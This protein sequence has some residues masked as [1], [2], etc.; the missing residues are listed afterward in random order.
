MADDLLYQLTYEK[1]A[2]VILISEQYQNRNSPRWYSDLLGTAA[3]WVPDATKV[4]VENH[5]CGSGFVWV[6][7]GEVLL[8]SCYLTPNESIGEFTEK[9]TSLEDTVQSLE[10]AAI[11]AGDFNAKAL[12]WGMPEP[13]RRGFSYW[14]WQPG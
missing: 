3:I 4:R 2:D 9:L 5:G 1:K 6:R 8:V 11:V 12:E 10:G 14:R 13:D 7:I